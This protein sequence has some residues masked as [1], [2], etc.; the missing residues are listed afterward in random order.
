LKRLDSGDLDDFLGW[1]FGADAVV[2]V[3]AGLLTDAFATAAVTVLELLE[4]ALDRGAAAAMF[5]QGVGP[6]ADPD[7]AGWCRRVLP[8]LDLIALREQRAGLPLLRTL[9]VDSSTV[10]TTGDDAIE[11][12]L[13]VRRP[14][15]RGE[16]IGVS[17]RRARYS[18]VDDRLL[19]G[20]A[21]VL[22]SAAEYHGAPLVPVPISRYHNERDAQVI[23]AALGREEAAAA[24]PTSP[25]ALVREIQRCRVVVTGSYHAGVFALAQGIPAVGLARSGYY[26]DKF[27]GL[28]EQFGG[29]CPV[30]RLDDPAYE[31]ELS[32]TIGGLWERADEL[33]PKLITAAQQQVAS[34]WASY[35]RFQALA[36]SKGAIKH[37]RAASEP[38]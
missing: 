21:G 25:E 12:A 16:G 22:R 19:A 15:K 5:G 11:L 36:E 37:T 14:E 4:T 28:S 8:R 32:D 18:D 33:A 13:R 35:R 26:V 7:L 9:G 30:V 34:S 27:L 31:Q 23:A 1:I 20:V 17:L 38:V 29:S 24:E 10:V 3:G 2:V 6:L